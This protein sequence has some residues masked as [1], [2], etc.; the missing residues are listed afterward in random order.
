MM[1]CKNG[2][3]GWFC[4]VY[5]LSFG[6]A[7]ITIECK[8]HGQE[9]AQSGF[10]LVQADLIFLLRLA[11]L[12]HWITRLLLGRF[13][14]NFLSHSGKSTVKLILVIWR[15]LFWSPSCCLNYVVEIILHGVISHFRLMS[16]GYGKDH[17]AKYWVGFWG[18][19]RSEKN[20]SW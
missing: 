3:K 4:L 5:Y 13:V 6:D 18:G 14:S 8:H 19:S 1:L 10:I 16:N 20:S 17:Q 12:C 9:A 7:D 11:D 2:C 15:T